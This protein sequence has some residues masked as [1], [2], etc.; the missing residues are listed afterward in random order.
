[1]LSPRGSKRT[2]PS[3]ALARGSP[4]RARAGPPR[5]RS[6][7]GVVAAGQPQLA[8]DADVRALQDQVVA[9]DV[10]QRPLARTALTAVQVRLADQGLAVGAHEAEVLD[11]RRGLP[12]VVAVQVVAVAGVAARIGVIQPAALRGAVE[13]RALGDDAVAAVLLG[14]A[15]PLAGPAERRRHVDEVQG[16]EARVGIDPAAVGLPEGAVLGVPA[17]VLALEPLE[18]ALVERIKAP[19][20]QRPGGE[21][22]DR[23]AVVDAVDDPLAGALEHVGGDVEAEL[24]ELGDVGAVPVVAHPA[25]PLVQERLGV[26]AVAREVL[27][28]DAEKMSMKAWLIQNACCRSRSISGALWSSCRTVSSVA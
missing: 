3:R 22:E 21:G 28:D 26:G 16:Q 1:M 11:H 4:G 25:V 6:A 20:G 10:R 18:V 7:V 24:A 2:G 27:D 15:Q 14:D 17:R 9:A 23:V 13:A 5:P 12:A 19:E 8:R